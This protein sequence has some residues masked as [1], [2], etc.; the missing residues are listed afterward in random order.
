MELKIG[1]IAKAHTQKSCFWTWR[2]L[3]E[4]GRYIYIGI[5]K[6]I[7]LNNYRYFIKWN[8][9]CRQNDR[10]KK[11]NTD[12][13]KTVVIFPDSVYDITPTPGMTKMI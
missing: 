3:H 10:F 1:K 4:R 12:W 8:N 11:A 13:L 6:I 2:V 9:C 7:I 5:Y